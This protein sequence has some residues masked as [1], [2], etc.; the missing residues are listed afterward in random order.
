MWFDL[1]LGW[2]CYKGR[3]SSGPFWKPPEEWSNVFMMP[4]GYVFDFH[5]QKGKEEKRK[6][7]KISFDSLKVSF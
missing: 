2:H 6:E 3:L 4:F 7:K 5:D 1:G